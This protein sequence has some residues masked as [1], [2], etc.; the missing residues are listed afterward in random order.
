MTACVDII[1]G[2]A[3]AE[4]AAYEGQAQLVLTSPPYDD[5]RDFGGHAFDWPAM[6]DAIIPTLAPGGVLV[7]V[8]GDKV[9]KGS[10]RC[11]PQRQLLYMQERGLTIHDVMAYHKQGRP[12]QSQNRHRPSWDFMF[13]VSNGKPAT[14]NLICDVPNKNPGMK[15]GGANKRFPDGRNAKTKTSIVQPYRKRGNVWF[16][17]TGSQKSHPDFPDA[18]QHSGTFPLALAR[19]H[20]TTWTNPG[21]LV[22]DPM[23]GSGTTL[24]AA[25]ELGRR[26]VGIEIHDP[27]VDLMRRRMAPDANNAQ[28]NFN[29]E[30]AN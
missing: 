3:I 15:G 20:I 26:A 16:Y 18:H 21:D 28:A 4:L 22:I 5:M 10:L 29:R 13:V 7:W 24:A 23:A 17:L 14:V 11:T 2:D 30:T 1:H 27:Y 12:L 6:I 8:V 9:D 25:A 19:D